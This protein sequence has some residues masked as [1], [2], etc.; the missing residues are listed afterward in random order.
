MVNI[1]VNILLLLKYLIEYFVKNYK[2]KNKLAT[3]TKRAIRLLSTKRLR[4]GVDPGGA[5]GGA[6]MEIPGA[7]LVSHDVGSRAVK[8]VQVFGAT[9]AE[10]GSRTVEAVQIDKA[11]LLEHVRVE[12]ALQA[13]DNAGRPVKVRIDVYGYEQL[14]V[15]V[16]ANKSVAIAAI[17]ASPTDLA[18]AKGSVVT[19]AG[20]DADLIKRSV[21]NNDIQVGDVIV[22][23]PATSLT[24]TTKQYIINRIEYDDDNPTDISNLVVYATTH[25]GGDV[26]TAENASIF[27]VRAP[28]LRKEFTGDIEQYGSFSGDAS[29]DPSLS[30]GIMIRPKTLLAPS[31]LIVYEQAASGW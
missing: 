23:D 13:A 25:S 4:I 11:L 5:L 19:F 9:A 1:E 2:G 31:E 18:K 6:Y 17:G 29:G 3:V 30:G 10:T 16:I 7:S 12:R 22:I 8:Q 24:D 27:S 20:S 14:P 28:G 26:T 15:D 21:I